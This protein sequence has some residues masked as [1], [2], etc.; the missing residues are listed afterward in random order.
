MILFSYK[1]SFH[2]YFNFTNSSRRSIFSF[3]HACGLTTS[4]S[5]PPCNNNLTNCNITLTTFTVKQKKTFFKIL[6]CLSDCQLVSAASRES[7][8]TGFN[9]QHECKLLKQIFHNKIGIFLKNIKILRPLT[10]FKQMKLLMM[11]VLAQQPI[12][13]LLTKLYHTFS[14]EQKF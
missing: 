5:S 2:Y 10:V 1:F 11:E 12:G 14:K 8:N 4:Q 13:K 7:K 6:N 3:R 9:F